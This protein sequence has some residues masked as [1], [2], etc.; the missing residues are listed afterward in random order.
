MPFRPGH[1]ETKFL[2]SLKIKNKDIEVKADG[3]T[4]VSNSNNYSPYPK[5]VELFLNM[6]F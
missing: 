4:K 2:E 5:T 1:E 3:C 6:A